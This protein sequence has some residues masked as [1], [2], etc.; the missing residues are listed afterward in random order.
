MRFC[1]LLFLLALSPAWCSDAD[2]IL[3]IGD[4]WAQLMTIQNALQDTL[5]DN[6]RPDLGVSFEVTA[7]GGTTAAQWASA[8][9]LLLINLALSD[10]PNLQAAQLTMGGNDFLAGMND[11]GWFQGMDQA[12]EVAL[13]DQIT[14]DM[15]RVI[16]HLLEQ[17]PNL[18]ILISLYDYLN[19]E[20]QPCSNIANRLGNP[21]P[22]QLNGALLRMEDAIQTF[23]AGRAQV[24]FVSHAGLMQEAFGYP[25]GGFEP[26]DLE[27]PGDPSFPS[28]VAA[29]VDCIHLN[30][31]GYRVLAQNLWENF[32]AGLTD[33]VNRPDSER[34]L[35][36]ITRTTGGF[37]TTLTLYNRGQIDGTITLLAYDAEGVALANPTIAV[38]AGTFMRIL[39]A[40]LY[41]GEM[42]HINI[43]GSP[44]IVVTATYKANND[45]ASAQVNEQNQSGTRW[46]FYPA[47]PDLVFDGLA[48]LNVG[49]QPAVLDLRL[50]LENGTEV[51]IARI[52]SGLAPLHK[53][54]VVISEVLPKTADG[55]IEVVSS[56]PI[57][58]VALRGS[59]GETTPFFLYQTAPVLVAE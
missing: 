56:Q 18:E 48:I 34:W 39:A 21:T 49:D 2:R 36:H 1:L 52:N 32:Y 50:F 42:S 23:F 5:A 43:T 46:L 27:Q 4:S 6:G 35:P 45:G 44:D 47:E 20:D 19:L 37:N 22:A 10:S 26:G 13:F 58:V 29:M 12:A 57:Q 8:E 28:P 9:G 51:G 16:T 40:S 31:A 30:I 15:N 59:L 3:V 33:H 7:I 24:S 25:Q 41:P 17:R 54:L 11:G 14:T 55:A 53:Q 38:P